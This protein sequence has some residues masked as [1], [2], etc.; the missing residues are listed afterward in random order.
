MEWMNWYEAERFIKALGPVRAFDIPA[1]AVFTH[2]TIESDYFRK[3]CGL[4]G[5]F[6]IQRPNQ[7]KPWA[8]QG[9]NEYADFET[10]DEALHFYI[11]RLKDKFPA[12]LKCGL[13]SHCFIY[14]LKGWNQ[15]NSY[16]DRMMERH[17]FLAGEDAVIKLFD[18]HL[19]GIKYV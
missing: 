19:G 4:N 7:H 14:G 9:D 6:R 17:K 10:V 2:A 1:L 8:K 18:I 15:D 3:I 16:T 13:C 12:S 5:H 11:R